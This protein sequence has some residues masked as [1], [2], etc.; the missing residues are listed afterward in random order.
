[1]QEQATNREE[2]GTLP[3]SDLE[4]WILSTLQT[5][6]GFAYEINDKHYLVNAHYAKACTA[7]ETKKLKLY[8]AESVTLEISKKEDRQKFEIIKKDARTLAEA[9][10]VLMEDAKRIGKNNS[11]YRL[12]EILQDCTHKELN[13]L[14]DQI[15]LFEKAAWFED[16]YD[17][18][19][20][21]KEF[22]DNSGRKGDLT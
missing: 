6:K 15:E 21:I 18:L 9:M 4:K 8:L 10:T 3:R 1:M 13:R 5:K 7:E 12:D 2:K 16:Y 22:T 20:R 17:S 11:D 14:K 19:R